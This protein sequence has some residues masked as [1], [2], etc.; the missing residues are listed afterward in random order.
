MAAPLAVDHVILAVRDLDEASRRLRAELGLDCLDGGV[1]PGWG[2]GNRIAPLGAGQYL[3]LLGVVNPD[4]ASAHPFGQFVSQVVAEGD[5][6]MAWCVAAAEIEEVA[7]RLG[8]EVVPGSRVRPDGVEIRWRLAGLEAAMLEPSL[9]FFISWEDP[10]S[11][12]ASRSADHAVEM[13]GIAGI[14]VGGDPGR[15]RDW[16]GGADLPVTA[17]GDRRGLSR[18]AIRTAEGEVVLR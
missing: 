6:L 18:V 15:L 11:H 9:P 13:Q 7:A 8:L 16:L 2:T 10:A 14:E 3:E 12:P 1:H 5:R 17:T 4:E